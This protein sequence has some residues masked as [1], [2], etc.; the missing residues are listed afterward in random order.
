MEYEQLVRLGLSQD[1]DLQLIFCSEQ[2]N[3]LLDESVSLVYATMSKLAAESKL[4]ELRQGDDD[5]HYMIYSIPLNTDLHSLAKFKL[6]IKA[7]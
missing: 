6:I 2:A 5:N 4:K 1:G 3:S 7:K